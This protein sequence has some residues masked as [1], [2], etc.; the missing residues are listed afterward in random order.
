MNY[1]HLSTLGEIAS[2][3][4]SGATPKGGSNSYKADGISLIRS[5]NVLDFKFSIEGLAYIDDEQADELKN[6]TVEENDILLNITGDSVARCCIVPRETLPARVNQHV[7]II[8]VNYQ[9]AH[10]RFIF[11]LLQEMKAE[12]LMQAEIGA[13]RNALTKG[14]LES[15]PISI[16]SSLAVQKKIADVLTSLDDKIDLLHRQ[17]KTL[18]AMGETLFRQ[19]FVE[20]AQENWIECSVSDFADHAKE[21]VIPQNHAD[22]LFSHYSI[23]AFDNERRPTFEPG[24]EIL[25]NKF[26][27]LPYSI[28]VSKLN[29]RTPRI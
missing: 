17:N 20:D 18:E 16:P 8:R 7:A 25:S 22:T 10:Y 28:L 6:V 15:L 4:G 26:K 14:M 24:R 3:I 5:Q 29:P 11:Y 9:K 21:N 27:V 23:P 1:L 12:L 19:W 2:K 13:T